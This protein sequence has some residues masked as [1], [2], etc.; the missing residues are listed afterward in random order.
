MLTDSKIKSLKPKEKL[1]K[2]A[3]RDRLY[4]T[5]SIAGTI[6]F[7][8][9]Y[10]L[11]GRCETLTIGKYGN[12]DGINLAE[13]RK[14]LMLTRKQVSEGISPANLKRNKKDQNS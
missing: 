11:N 7:C 2:V 8:Y 6:T 3:D 9:D 4:V 5:V 14:K 13:A 12:D 10:R 1:Y